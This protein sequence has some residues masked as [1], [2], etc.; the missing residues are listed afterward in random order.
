MRL[1]NQMSEKL[2]VKELKPIAVWTEC[3]SYVLTNAPDPL[4]GPDMYFSVSTLSINFRP[5][6]VPVL[7]KNCMFLDKVFIS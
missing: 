7:F 6:L 1:Q 5:W 3:S 2:A 4:A